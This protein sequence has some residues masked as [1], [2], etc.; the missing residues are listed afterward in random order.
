MS[1]FVASR[2]AVGG[3]ARCRLCS[4][5]VAVFGRSAFAVSSGWG[6]RCDGGAKSKKNPLLFQKKVYIRTM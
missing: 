3:Y 6:S 2:L 4:L 5:S 1:L